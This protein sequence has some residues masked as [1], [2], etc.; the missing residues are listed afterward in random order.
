MATINLSINDDTYTA[1]AAGDLIYGLDGND[2]ITASSGGNRL[3]GGNGD[4]TLNGGIGDD[5][6]QGDDTNNWNGHN[7]LNGNGGDDYILSNSS[8]DEVNAGSGNDTVEVWK[9]QSGQVFKGGA[10]QDNLTLYAQQIMVY[11]LDFSSSFTVRKGIAADW[12]TFTGFESLTFIGGEFTCNVQASELGDFLTINNLHSS[13]FMAGTLDGRGGND[14]FVI[15]GVTSDTVEEVVGGTG[16]DT[17]AWSL[18]TSSVSNITVNATAGTIADGGSQFL[19]FSS[20]ETLVV[21][22]DNLPGSLS[23][24]GLIGAD[25]VIFGGTSANIDTQD[26]NDTITINSGK[27]NV[28][29][30]AGN[31][32]VSVSA[33]DLSKVRISC[34]DGND[35]A[36]GAANTV[37]YGEAGNDQLTAGRNGCSLYGGTGNDTLSRTASF[38]DTATSAA[39]IDGGAG[40]DTLK[41]TLSIISSTITLDFSQAAVTL[42]D[43][44]T[45]QNVEIVQYTGGFGVDIV[46]SSAN[47]AGAS[48]NLVSGGWGNDILT[49]AN[50]GAA[51]DGGYGDDRLKGGTG[52]DILNGG[53]GGND[54]L[55]GGAGNDQ[56]SGSTGKDRL[57]G[58]LGADK[59]IFTDWDGSLNAPAMRDIITDFNR[60]QG[61]KINVKAIDA[62]IATVGVEDAFTFAGSVFHNKAG[63]LIFQKFDKAGTANDYTLISG[64]LTGDGVAEFMIQVKGLIDFKATDFIL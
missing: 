55:S 54:I 10:G 17:L 64:D 63:E 26:G 33:S 14:S 35:V 30:G 29:A 24:Q 19:H 6:L 3:Y 44:T 20:I 36:A 15:N 28:L 49:A 45:I 13:T 40:I 57:Q 51:L 58:G 16:K 41:L 8:R 47:A 5:Y 11:E 2:V 60:A 48:V 4:D 39:H 27:A 1:L 46:T 50:A 18:G 43:G 9:M 56:L 7:I 31:D 52:N 53:F 32:S 22:A 59:F 37:I 42:L 23:Y 61:D 62:I 25:S 38:A 34:G 21:Q 12:A